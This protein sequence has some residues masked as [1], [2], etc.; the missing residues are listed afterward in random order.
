MQKV[1]NVGKWVRKLEKVDCILVKKGVKIIAANKGGKKTFKF[2]NK[3]R[4]TNLAHATQ[5]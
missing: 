4:D 2:N 3:N 5:Q 1:K